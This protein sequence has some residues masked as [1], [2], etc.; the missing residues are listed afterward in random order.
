MAAE[1][2]FHFHRR[3]L[4]L[5]PALEYSDNETVAAFRLGLG[6]EFDAAQF[7]ITPSVHVESERGGGLAVQPQRAFRVVAESFRNRVPE[8]FS[9]RIPDTTHSE[10]IGQGSEIDGI[11]KPWPS[12]DNPLGPV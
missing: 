8:P 10:N 3:E 11:G 5:V 9:R 2:F 4:T 7:L 6:R 1:H 12:V